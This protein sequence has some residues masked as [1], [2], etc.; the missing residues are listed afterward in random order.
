[1]PPQG[2]GTHHYH[3]TLYALDSKMVA[4][5]GETKKQLLAEIED[6]TLATGRLTG[7]YSR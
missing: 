6:H 3:F 5:P 2:H 7:V 1:M 4:G